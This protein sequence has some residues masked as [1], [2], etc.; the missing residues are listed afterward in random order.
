MGKSARE[1]R[2]RPY[3]AIDR[4]REV[5]YVFCESS[6]HHGMNSAN[7]SLYMGT[8]MVLFPQ[9]S[10]EN[11]VDTR[12]EQLGAGLRLRRATPAEIRKAVQT[13]L[14]EQKY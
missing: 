10:E 8:P 14:D 7:E 13:V 9:H 6:T 2:L 11:A 3:A 1:P 4:E 12:V 5:G